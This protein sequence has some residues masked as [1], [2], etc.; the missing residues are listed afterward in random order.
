MKK[1]WRKIG[2]IS[3]LALFLFSA[4][5]ACSSG[6][7]GG[8]DN[9]DASVER[10]TLSETHL[11][12]E[13]GDT[14]TL[15]AALT[16]AGSTETVT[17]SSDD[18]STVSVEGGVLTALK[19]GNAVITATAGTASDYCQ[20]TVV[21]Q[22][23]TATDDE[24]KV[25][26]YIYYENFKE[27]ET[28]PNYFKKSI[29]GTGAAAITDEGLNITLVGSG[30]SFLSHVFEETLSGR[31]EVK[32]KVKV[33]SRAFSNILFFY[34]GEQGTD[35]ND[36][37]VTLGMNGGGFVNHY[38]GSWHQIASNS[39]DVWYDIT[40][41]LDI[42]N[43]VFDLTITNADTGAPVY[44]GTQ[45]F[46]NTGDGV[47]DNIKLLKM[48]TDNTD[49][50]SADITWEYVTIQQ[51]GTDRAPAFE[52]EQTTY[53]VVLSDTPEE[54]QVELNYDVIGEPDPTVSVA[55]KSEG[56]TV[57]ADNKTVTFTAAGVYTV[58]LEAEN[59]LGTA[60]QTFTINVRADANTYLDTEFDVNPGFTFTT[61]GSATAGITD[62]KLSLVTATSGSSSAFA[63]YDFGEALSG[64]VYAEAEITYDSTGSGRF[65]NIFYLFTEGTT[66]NDSSRATISIAIDR[67][68]L[69][70]N[71]GGWKS[72]NRTVTAGT[73]FTLGVT[74][75]FDNATM[76]V[77]YDG[78]TVGTDLSFRNTSYADSTSVMLIG[79]DKEG[80]S[81]S[82]NSM[83]LVKVEAPEITVGEATGAVDIQ[84]DANYTLPYTVA[85]SDATV[86]VTGT[87]NT[88]WTW[89]Q[90]Q[91]NKAVTFTSAGTYV[92]TITATGEAG[93]SSQATITVT[94]TG[95]D[96]A[97]AIEVTSGDA[98]GG[99]A[100]A[101]QGKNVYT[102]TYDVTGSPAPTV[103]VAEST[104]KETGWTY[105]EEEGLI[106]FTK[107]GSY[108]F[109]VTAS[110]GVGT[111]A[112]DTFAVT[113]N[114]R[115]IGVS[116]TTIE[117][118]NFNA[119]S[120]TAPE[121]FDVSGGTVD[122]TANGVNVAVS[123]GSAFVD[124]KFDSAFS[125]IVSAEVTFTINS[126]GGSAFANLLFFY[127]SDSDGGLGSNAA[128]VAVRNDYN[129][130]IWSESSSGGWTD[131]RDANDARVDL[132][133]GAE[134]TVRM[135]N[136]FDNEVSYFY[137]TGKGTNYTFEETYLGAHSFRIPGLTV[138][139]IRFGSDKSGT[140]FTIKSI[141]LEQINENEAE[142]SN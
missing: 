119:A 55:S 58:T 35:T 64:T 82:Y 131:F 14:E 84:E 138:D 100:L 89:Q 49:N 137:L 75:D 48:G 68:T 9:T 60:E 140:D 128:A 125:G 92:F 22:G 78:V 135:V 40:M 124:Y 36:G 23:A 43:S 41:I 45:S 26:G 47:E 38:S 29:T 31:V 63:R 133:D 2:L 54:N 67:G 110:N 122:W 15:T 65:A 102:L 4:A 61:S 83:K 132:D 16:P 120:D 44:N 94:V 33:G 12:M 136:D 25:E 81:F 126:S 42:G 106:T 115:F 127:S 53:S 24:T 70:Y 91:K 99:N 95:A 117:E 130:L 142:A 1:I 111:D 76:D 34:Q 101:L 18:A 85:P 88:G 77:T 28:V 134:Y 139:R 72:L 93:A 32:T 20:V 109:V 113:V 62:N 66:S 73:T 80:D 30:Q 105:D 19:T 3:L 56:V 96:E 27:R 97:P 5:V 52:T 121:G 90:G 7:N 71:A 69:Q 141:T 74:M 51:L 112:T 17:W 10:L 8:D 87:P 59:S 123:S 21:E 118:F 46:R 116:G 13:I 107:T 108:E 57:A 86:T 6:G 11:T 37:I 104:G 114:D 98:T 39:N 50:G 129:A 103:S 79:S